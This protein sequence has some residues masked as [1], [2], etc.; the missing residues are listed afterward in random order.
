MSRNFDRP[1]SLNKSVSELLFAPLIDKGIHPTI[2]D[3]GARNGMFDLPDSYAQQAIFVGFEPNKVEYDKLV[4]G[5]TDAIKCG[6][7]PVR[8]TSE[9]YH[10][11]ALWSTEEERTFYV[12][13]GAGA[14][15]LMGYTVP[16]ITENMFLDIDAGESYGARH[17]NVRQTTPVPCKPLDSVQ[18]DTVD[19]LK[20]DVEG[21]ELDIMQGARKLFEAQDILFI[22]TEFVFTPYYER[23]P[24]LGHQHVFLDEMGLRLL[25]LDAQHAKYARGKTK[26]PANADRRMVYAG[27]AFFAI[28]PDRTSL[29]AEKSH[30]LAVIAIVYGFHSFGVSLLR[31]AALISSNEID[32]IEQALSYLPLRARLKSKWFDFPNQASK[33]YWT[34]RRL[35]S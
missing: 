27:D 29:S 20:I 35:F 31:D 32:Q 12:T 33:V 17:T 23:H 5:E 19:Y 18:T 16:G 14:C 21:A 4:A 34:V 25:D 9:K 30:R 6:I 1:T 11:M 28:D 10:N 3:A 24:V 26:I 2:V 13:E 22:K 15:T 8:Y 7:K